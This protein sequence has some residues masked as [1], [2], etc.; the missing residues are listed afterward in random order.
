MKDTKEKEKRS[1]QLKGLD[2][3]SKPETSEANSS[4][5]NGRNIHG[6]LEDCEYSPIPPVHVCLY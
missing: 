3:D 5:E 4:S 2:D 6:S 1:A